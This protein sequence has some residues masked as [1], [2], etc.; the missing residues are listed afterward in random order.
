M[1]PVPAAC[2]GSPWPVPLSPRSLREREWR[3]SCKGAAGFQATYRNAC[4]VHYT[5]MHCGMYGK[6][7]ACKLHAALIP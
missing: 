6:L 2:C 1:Q 3:K 7:A 4:M 5:Y